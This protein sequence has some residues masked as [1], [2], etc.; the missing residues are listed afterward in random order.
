M[1][2]EQ[3]NIEE[4]IEV[5]EMFEEKIQKILNQTIYKEQDDLA[6]EIRLKII[7]KLNT[8]EFRDIPGFWNFIENNKSYQDW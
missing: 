3:C 8:L 2:K 5:L 6:Q 1:E 7:E 4:I